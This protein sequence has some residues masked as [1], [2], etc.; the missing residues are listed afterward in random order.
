MASADFEH[1]A[2]EAASVP[3]RHGE[4]PARNEDAG[5]LAGNKLWPWREHGAEHA[6]DYVE[7][8]V[9]VRHGLRVAL[10][11]LDVQ[12]GCGRAFAGLLEQVWGNVNTR[13]EAA[14][15][16]KRNGRV[17]GTASDVQD[18]GSRRQRQPVD[19]EFSGCGYGASDLTEVP[20]HPGGAHRGFDLV[21]RRCK[22]RHDDP[23]CSGS[24]P[25]VEARQEKGQSYV[26][27]SLH[28]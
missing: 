16:G 13:D 1:L 7:A 2:G 23:K 14:G 26:G 25:S 27:F 28:S 12:I 6:D 11:E 20:G 18:T 17:P 9:G 21:E 22:G 15:T 24:G 19:K 10:V 8:L 3:V 4:A 5:E